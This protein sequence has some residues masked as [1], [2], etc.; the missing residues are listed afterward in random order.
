M[1]NSQHGHGFL[2][3]PDMILL[4][5]KQQYELQSRDNY[6]INS[7]TNKRQIEE[8]EERKGTDLGSEHQRRVSGPRAMRRWLTHQFGRGTAAMGMG[9]G[10]MALLCGPGATVL[11]RRR[12]ASTPIFSPIH[13]PH[14]QEWI[15]SSKGSS[16]NHE[17]RIRKAYPLCRIR[18]PKSKPE[19]SRKIEL[20][21]SP[22]KRKAALRREKGTDGGK[23][24]VK[25]KKKGGY[26]IRN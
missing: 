24:K 2:R 21:N 14:Y 13:I 20:K 16:T 8:E 7:E 22:S 15:S 26:V 1:S 4:K 25:K 11:L 10:M 18:I 5:L 9:M 23:K 12:W 19:E 17:I 6:K 3:Q